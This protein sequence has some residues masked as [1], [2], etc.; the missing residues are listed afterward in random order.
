MRSI[1][2]VGRKGKRAGWAARAAEAELSALDSRVEMIQALLPLALEAVNQLLQQE[3]TALA[4]QR[5]RHASGQ[6]GHARW[7]RQPG[8]V[9]LADQKVAIDV[10]RVRDL[11]HDLEVPLRTYQGLRRPRRAEEAALRK[12]LKGLSCR[13]Y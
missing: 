13:S 4:G 6:P 10:P 5:Y 11:C 7:G 3:V 1:V 12:I 8:S 2:R 9:Y